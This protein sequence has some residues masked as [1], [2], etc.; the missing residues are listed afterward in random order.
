MPP[1]CHMTYMLARSPIGVNVPL[2]VSGGSHSSPSSR[3]K[4][5]SRSLQEA[6]RHVHRH[7]HVH[8]HVCGA[9][10][11]PMCRFRPIVIGLRASSLSSTSSLASS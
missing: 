3:V 11:R 7:R 9:R 1:I 8:V 10:F 2:C 4:G 6:H 5:S